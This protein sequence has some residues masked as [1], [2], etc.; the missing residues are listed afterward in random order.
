MKVCMWNVQGAC[1]DLF[2]SHAKEVIGSHHP[3][4]FIFL[5]TKSDGSRGREVMRL[6][7]YD[8]CRIVRPVEKRGGIWL[9]WKKTVDLIDFDSEN[10][11][12]HSLFHF[13]N[14]GKEALVSGLHAPS[15]SGARHKYW[16]GMQGDLPPPTTPWLVLGDLNEITAQSEKKGGRAFKPAQCTDLVNFMDDAGLVDI[17]YNG[18]P[19]TWTNA[20]QGAA[21]IQERLD[22]ALVN[23]VWLN[24]FPFTKVHH[25]PRTYSDHAPILISLTNPNH[26]GN[27][28]FRCKEVWLN[29][30]NFHSYFVNNWKPPT[31]DFIQGRDKF[32]RTVHSWNYNIFGNLRNQKRNILARINGIQISLSKH[33]SQFLVNLEARLLED[34]NDIYKKERIIWAQKAGINW[35]KFGDYNT[36]YFHTLAKIK[37]AQGKILTLQNNLGDWITDQKSLRNLATTYFVNLFTTTHFSSLLNSS[38]IGNIGLDDSKKSMFLARVTLDEVRLN[39][40]NMD[41]TKSPGPDGIQPIFFQ[42]FWSDMN[43]SLS[44]FCVSCFENGKIPAEINYSYIALIPKIQGPSSITE[45]RP[46]G[47]CNTIY[48]LI[49]KIISSRLK[50]VLH[51]IVSPLQSSFIQG[52]GIEDNVIL[53]KEMAHVFHK[54]KK[55]NKIMALK[56]D[57]SKAYDSLEWDFIRDTLL[58]FNFPH[59]TISLIMSCITSSS[60]SILWNG[61]ICDKFYPTRGIRQ[62]DPLSSYIFVLCL[63]RLST[64]I[65]EQVH[66]GLWNPISISKNIKLSH[67]FYADDVF[68]FSTA[69][70]RNLCNIMKT[71]EDFGHR[72]GL[73]ISMQKS[74]IIFPNTM[75][76]SIRHEIANPYGLRIS[77]C[78]GKYLGIDIR[79]NK[80]KISNYLQLLDKSTNKVKGWQAKLLNMAGRCTLVKSV[81]NS[82][83]VYVMQTNILPISIV[84]KIEKCSRKFLWNKTERNRYMTRI[85]WE[86][87]TNSIDNGGLGIRR[88]KEWNL[89]FMAKL[90]WS[91]LTR[92]DKLWVQVFKENYIKKSN[93]LDCIPNSNQSP[94]W[95]DILKGRPILKKGLI[96]NIGNGKSTSLW[97]HHWIGDGPLY[98]L[99]DVKIPYSK[100]HWYVNRIIRGGKWYLEDIIHLIPNQIKNLIL[101]YPLSSNDKEEDFIRWQYSKSGA[102]TIKS[103]YYIQLNSSLRSVDNGQSF[104]RSIWKIKVPYKYRMLIWNCAHEILPVAQGLNRVIHQIS[105][106]C[107]RCLSD[108]ESHIHLFRD[109][110]Q[111]S[112]LWSFIFQRIWNTENFNLSSFYNLQ[113]KQWIK[114]NLSCSMRWKVLFSVAIWHIWISRNNAIFNL[115]MK[116][117]FSLYNSFFVDW[118][119]TNFIL[120]GKDVKQNQV[121]G[122]FAFKWL[123]PKPD[124]LKLNVDGAWKSMTEAGGGGV[125][126]RPNGSWFV[127]FS[128]KFN[129]SSPLAAELYALRE[130]LIIAKDLSM[131]KLEVE[132]DAVQLKLMLEKM[133]ENSYHELGPVLKEV[134]NMLSQNWIITFNHIPRFCNKV[135]HDLAA[136]SL[137]MAVGHKLHYIIPA[138]AKEHYFKELELTN[139]DY[140]EF[141]RG[142]AGIGTTGATQ[143]TPAVPTTSSA[144]QIVFGSIVTDIKQA[145]DIA[146]GKQQLAQDKGKGKMFEPF[147]VGGST[148]S[149]PIEIVEL[150]D[151]EV[152]NN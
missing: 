134:A 103:A 128:C 62:G 13:K 35:R 55:R 70:A 139:L 65:E 141:V 93:F 105:S 53:V 97:F 75:H 74:T 36:K 66:L 100:A 39:L 121:A 37:K 12:F 129:V 44:T 38:T 78:F 47:L 110:A 21:L 49:A 7:N 109:C 123:P 46:I 25:L 107:S 104:W 52:R 42:R 83:P 108:Q 17:G 23:S 81:L 30:P 3:D 9:F 61:E 94:L 126:R 135:A 106:I 76:N 68:L 127:G 20:R 131:D 117:C 5:E 86:N 85:S 146:R 34:L 132:T 24:S 122:N 133:D 33:Y 143:V 112:I 102:F 16:R 10:N 48:K 72:S 58:H 19:Y 89:S 96:I 111:S 63:D 15:S 43:I 138:C 84:N 98:T 41:P 80:L 119:S 26:S 152:A 28:P 51:R 125:F 18:C 69:S 147:V 22:R 149:N 8:D 27:Y 4:I 54:A 116:H 73:R 14:L 88:L 115:Q 137:V 2:L 151:G 57:I 67:V 145:A 113:W 45:F 29:H 99:K 124:F 120:Q 79:P 82:F 77:T 114:F 92:P 60:I 56:L 59:K 6:L 101:A 140:A 50:Q 1:R 144:A 148:V 91:I 11:H 40:F 87:V 31:E 95:R 90:G 136:H 142:E 150:E 64:M 118:K 32:L 130:G 71:L